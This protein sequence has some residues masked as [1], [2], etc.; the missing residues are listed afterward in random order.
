MDPAATAVLDWAAASSPVAASAGA[1]TA[2]LKVSSTTVDHNQAL[3]GEGGD[4]GNGGNGDGGG[5]YNAGGPATGP[6]TLTL[7]DATV[8]HN[9]A[10]GGEA[11]DWRQ[12][13]AGQ[14]RRG[15]HPRDVRPRRQ[16]RPKEPRHGPQIQRYLP[17]SGP[18]CHFQKSIA[19]WVRSGLQRV[20]SGMH[21]ESSGADT[22]FQGG[23]LLLRSARG[24]AGGRAGAVRLLAG[25]VI[26][27]QVLGDSHRPR[28]ACRVAG[29]GSGSCRPWK[30]GDIRRVRSCPPR[31]SRN[32]SVV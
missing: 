18:G 21:W 14:R 24:E 31:L 30:H 9:F 3:G 19:F 10:L 15:L 4:G 6:S 32:R 17:L 20:R 16:R 8:K 29:R 11:A 13:R 26:L 23:H 2:T 25:V 7:T 22:R 12:R 28:R 27:V 1:L 5:L